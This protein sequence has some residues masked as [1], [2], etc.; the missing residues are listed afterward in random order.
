M[1]VITC[2]MAVVSEDKREKNPI[3]SFT[4]MATSH[5]NALGKKNMKGV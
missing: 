5:A 1:L 4:N 2:S 3:K